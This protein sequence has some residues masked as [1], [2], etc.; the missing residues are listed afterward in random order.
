MRDPYEVLGVSPGASDDEIKKAYRKLS[1]KYHPD[2]NQGNPLAEE[3]FKEVQTAYDTI[4]K[5]GDSFGGYSAY[6]GSDESTDYFRA[7]ENY[8]RNGYYTEAWNVLS[9]MT[10]RPAHWYYLAAI[11]E[12]RRGNNVTAK[13]YADTA[14]RMEPGNP[15]Y[16]TLKM[17]IESGST[18]Y[19]GMGEDFGRTFDFGW[20]NN[21]CL[22]LCLLNLFCNVCCGGGGYFCGC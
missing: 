10:H 15:T 20:S 22:K 2:L 21:M 18:R 12:L 9:G 16:E 19:A 5:K 7:A 11:V 4:M 8:I 6:Q 17:N 13:E 1:K 14:V 3:K